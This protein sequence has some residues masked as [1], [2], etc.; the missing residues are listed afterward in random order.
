MPPLVTIAETPAFSQRASSILAEEEIDE[1]TEYL[2]RNPEAGV[3]IPKS[4]GI[5]KLR[6]AASG[7]GKSGGAR[8][9]Y[10][11][12][13]VDAPLLLIAIF[14]KNQKSNLDARELKAAQQLAESIAKEARNRK[15]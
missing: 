4:G 6:W 1:L 7:R 15:D 3:I 11:Y 14:A 12:H 10:Y 8:V 5:R 13:N 2:G 9:I